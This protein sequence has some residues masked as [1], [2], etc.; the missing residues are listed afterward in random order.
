MDYSVKLWSPYFGKDAKALERKQD[1]FTNMIPGMTYFGY[2]DQQ[3]N[4]GLLSLEQILQ[5]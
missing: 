2:V 4:L 1:R 3:K 5:V